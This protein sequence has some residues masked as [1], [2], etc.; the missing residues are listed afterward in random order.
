MTN[1]LVEYYNVIVAVQFFLE[2][3]LKTLIVMIEKLKGPA[4]GKLHTIQLIEADM[5]LIMRIL[6]NIRNKLDIESDDRVS[7][8]KYG[9]RPGYSIEDD[10]L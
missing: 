8:S 5:Q 4:L 3:W 6:V 9:S 2:R 7:K 10:I 1:K